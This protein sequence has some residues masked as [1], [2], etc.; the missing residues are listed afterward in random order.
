MLALIVH[1]P[2]NIEMLVL[3][4]M[5]SDDFGMGGHEAD[6]PDAAGPSQVEAF[7]TL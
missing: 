3:N 5:V 7:F 6:V 4:I 2:T 1:I